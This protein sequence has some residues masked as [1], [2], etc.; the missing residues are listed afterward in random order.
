MYTGYTT[1]IDGKKM[2]IVGYLEN[3]ESVM[4]FIP[5]VLAN[6]STDYSQRTPYMIGDKIGV[7][8]STG[9]LS[10][11][12]ESITGSLDIANTSTG[13]VVY[14]DNY[15]IKEGTGSDL[16]SAFLDKSVV[17]NT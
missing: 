10:P 14:F 1:T 2:Q 5:T 11:I 3:K 17:Y 13:Y 7:V 12:Q 8:M 9:T 16:K 4:S 15:T 6:S